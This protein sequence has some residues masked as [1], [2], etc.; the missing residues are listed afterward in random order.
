MTTPSDGLQRPPAWLAI[1]LALAVGFAL[2]CLVSRT[3]GIAFHALLTGPMPQLRWSDETGW[4]LMRLTRVGTVIEDT[5]T[6]S[7]LGLAVLF[8]FRARQFS[9]GADGQFFVGALAATW[10]GVQLGGWPL[11]GLPLALVAALSAG[12]LW[13]GIAGVLKARFGA[14]EIVTTLMLN[15]IA[16]QL[17]RAVVTHAFHDSGIAYVATP[18]V[19]T[20][21]LLLPLLP[22]THVTVLVLLVPLA[23][24]L[25]AWLLARTTLGYELR[26]VGDAPAFAAQTGVPVARTIALSM[27]IGGAFAGLAGFHLSHGLL[28]RLPVDL[29]PGLGFEG[30]VVALLAR[31][32]P[33]AVPLAA[34]LYAYLKTGAQAMELASDVSREMVLVI[35]A[36]IVLLVVS[37]R[38]LPA[39]WLKRRPRL[40]PDSA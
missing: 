11:L 8:G 31:N 22:R 20:P 25:A 29:N 1:A 5:V 30:L 18:A 34:L 23:T 9:I 40:N 26:V 4:Q 3:P 36:C 37:Q 6:L 2:T 19:P 28:K 10:V 21:A 38:L 32:Q 35:Q 15:L 16:V 33:R 39:A 14:S 24:A 12:F 7:L 17:F 27:A 13:G